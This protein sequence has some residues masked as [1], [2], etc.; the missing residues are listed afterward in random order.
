MASDCTDAEVSWLWTINFLAF[1]LGRSFERM[2][3]VIQPPITSGSANTV[4]NRE[5]PQPAAINTPAK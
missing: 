3:Y 1:Y 4:N 2:E 5:I